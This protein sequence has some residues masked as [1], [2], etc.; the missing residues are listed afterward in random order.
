MIS[1]IK[2]WAGDAGKA[3]GSKALV[4]GL[5][6]MSAMQSMAQGEGGG[7]PDVVNS[8]TTAVANAT[9]VFN[10][11]LGLSITA[12]AAGLIISFIKKGKK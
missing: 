4:G 12:I 7:A 10:S 5:L 1:K 8:L 9:T 3:F 2:E 6:V 11:V